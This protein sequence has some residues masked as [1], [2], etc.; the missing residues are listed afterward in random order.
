MIQ[1]GAPSP[2]GK[3]IVA[4][5]REA[6]AHIVDRVRQ[7][8]NDRD[9]S[10]LPIS[11]SRREAA[12]RASIVHPVRP[13]VGGEKTQTPRS[14]LFRLRLQRVVRA[15]AAIMDRP[16]ATKVGERLVLLRAGSCRIKRANCIGVS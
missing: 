5:Q 9:Q 6:I 10:P 4:V 15:Y 14:P 1:I 11:N 3:K 16:Y 8:I 7:F 13:G 12:G 2:K